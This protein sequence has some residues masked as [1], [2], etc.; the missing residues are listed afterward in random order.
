MNNTNPHI[1]DLFINGQHYGIIDNSN[2]YGRT[3]ILHKVEG[4]N[5]SSIT[6]EEFID[7]MKNGLAVA[8]EKYSNLTNDE[9]NEN[10]EKNIA[11][12][13]AVVL[14]DLR[15]K[16]KRESTVQKYFAEKMEGR[17]EAVEKH[18]S[19]DRNVS[20]TCWPGPHHGVPGVTMGLS[21]KSTEHSIENAFS[22]LS[23]NEWFRKGTGL[24]FKYGCNKRTHISFCG[25]EIE[26]LMSEKDKAAE[27]AG[28]KAIDDAI[29]AYYANKRPGEYCG[30]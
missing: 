23:E 22:K 17:R 19:Y 12:Y 6:K 25:G 13:A 10:I 28:Q 29:T 8:C 27:K 4:V 26:I 5:L 20:F 24:M 16:Y 15:K 1:S 30:D 11:D 14:R 18:Y 9:I 3:V 7:L 2:E 21:N